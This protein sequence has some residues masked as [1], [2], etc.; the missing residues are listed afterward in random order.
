MNV[1]RG[2]AGGNS[3]HYLVEVKLKIK[4]GVAER[5][6]S[7]EGVWVIRHMKLEEVELGIEY[8]EDLEKMWD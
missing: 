2:A 3:N 5:R 1:L 4:G 6:V 7:D 8:E